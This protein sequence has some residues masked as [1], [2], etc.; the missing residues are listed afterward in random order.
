MTTRVHYNTTQSKE[1]TIGQAQLQ[2]CGYKGLHLHAAQQY[3][4]LYTRDIGF[5]QA[6]P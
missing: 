5:A 1:Q 6:Y 4:I 2:L 3:S